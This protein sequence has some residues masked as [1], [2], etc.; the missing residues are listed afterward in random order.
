MGNIDQI[1]ILILTLVSAILTWKM[2]FD[3][4]KTK[5]HKVITHL[6]AVITASFMLLS[7]TIL[8][9][10]QDYQ[11]GSNEPQMV[12]SFSSVGILFIMLLILYIFFRYIPSRK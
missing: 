4:Y 6:I 9:I 12:L 1:I 5:I 10:N 2:V 8:F 3:F 11:R 7:T